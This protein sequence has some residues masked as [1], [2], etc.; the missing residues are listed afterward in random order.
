MTVFLFLVIIEALY[1]VVQQLIKTGEPKMMNLTVKPIQT[2]IATVV[3]TSYAT[4]KNARFNNTASNVRSIKQRWDDTFNSLPV[5]QQRAI[6]A[7][8]NAAIA[9]FHRRNPSINSWRT[10]KKEL[11]RA[12]DIKMPEIKIDGTMQRLLNI[13]WVLHLL[14]VFV[15]TKVIPIQ[16]YQPDPS[17]NEYLAWD[18]Q[19]TLVLLWLIAT[20]IFAEDPSTIEIPVNIYASHLK[21]EMRQSFVDLNGPAGKRGLD[22]F[23]I[24]EQMVYGVRIDQSKNPLW[25]IAEEKQTILESR[26][27]FLTSKKFGDYDMPG[28]ISR[29]QEVSKH[30]PTVLSWLCDYLVAVGVQG[31]PAEEKEMVMMSYF[32]EGCSLYGIKVN[33]KFITDIAGVALNKF[34]GDFSPTSI[35]WAKVGIAYRSWHH[36]NIGFGTPKP[37]K[38]PNH[39]YPFL[40]AQLEKDLPNYTF[41]GKRGS[42]EFTPFVKDLF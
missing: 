35:F 13:E 42:S 34:N 33:Q 8:L 39:G 21:P 1:K 10:L 25:M 2:A 7:G 28:A 38:E 20:Q 32:F 15:V 26:G 17:K 11:A 9:E 27:L 29:T 18:G 22:Q 23:D 5:N 30:T 37:S 40:V 12:I 6:T 19:H 36:A 24:F 16:V 3:S 31:R 4:T 41:P 14:N